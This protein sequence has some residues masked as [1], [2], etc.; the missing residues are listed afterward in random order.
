MRDPFTAQ[1]E[2]MK[3]TLAVIYQTGMAAEAFEQ[4]AESVN[5][6]SLTVHLEVREPQ[7]PFAGIMWTM[8]TVSA[9]FVAS[10][11]FGGILKELGKDHYLVLKDAM[12]KLTQKTMEMPRIEPT[13]FGTPGKVD[14]SDPFSMSFSIWAEIPNDRRVKLLIPKIADKDGYAKLSD[15]FLEFVKR[16]HEEGESA[17]AEIGFDVSRRSNPITVSY[18]KD[19]GAIEYVNPFVH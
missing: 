12:A 15:A 11:Y 2:P 18:N 17:L 6:K 19:T 5:G 8:M 1:I 14:K 9:A 13:L 3:P 10:N 16:C 7:G 4:F